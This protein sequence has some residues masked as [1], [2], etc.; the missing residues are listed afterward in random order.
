VVLIIALAPLSAT[1][2]EK[3]SKAATTGAFT[4]ATARAVVD[5]YCVG[6]HNDRLKTGGLSL[7]GVDLG[8]AG[9]HEVELEKMV[10]KLRGGV[11]PPAGNPRPDPM[12]SNALAAW[13]EQELD[14]AAEA[15]PNA[16]RTE[17]MHRLNRAEYR[18]AV[19]D[20]F[21]IEGLDIDQMLPSD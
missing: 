12:T 3:V 10:R 11:M 9:K 8:N 14:R 15:T 21:G 20:L 19:R 6:C 1:Q 17:G 7:A 2:Q 18:N 5:K 16:G 4:G 13:L